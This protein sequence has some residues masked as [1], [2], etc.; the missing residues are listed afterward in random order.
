MPQE[1]L[2]MQAMLGNGLY[3][4]PDVKL[5]NAAARLP[6]EYR[7]TVPVRMVETDWNKRPTNA[8][9][10]NTKNDQINV[11]STS[12]IYKDGDLDRLAGTLAHE[13][14]HTKGDPLEQE[15]YNT[16]AE[17]LRL[18]NPKKNKKRLEDILL[19]KRM[20]K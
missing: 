19:L 11:S 18:L 20:Y 8:W 6:K 10:D 15:A 16:E 13:T 5:Y 12:K 4:Y 7:P 3:Q 1:G 17:V 2:M 14:V 9:I